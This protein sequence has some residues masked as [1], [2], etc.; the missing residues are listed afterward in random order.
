MSRSVRPWPSDSECP[1]SGFLDFK[2]FLN[3]ASYH[4]AAE[5]RNEAA[6]ARYN[7]LCAATVA[8]ANEWPYWAMDRMFREIAPLVAWDSF[9]QIYINELR[10]LSE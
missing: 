9:M 4:N 1:E 10:K 6:E 7:I 5:G 2:K 8:L 3:R